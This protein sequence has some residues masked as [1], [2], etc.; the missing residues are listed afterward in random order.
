MIAPSI[1]IDPTILNQ[2]CKQHGVSRLALFGSAVRDDFDA[3]R[4]DIDLLVDFSPGAS[5]SLFKLVRMEQA[6]SRI[7]GRPVDLTTTGSLSK[8]FRDDVMSAAVVLY[9]AS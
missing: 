7:V 9:D 8:Y 6:L 5:K 4:S 2:F 3:A 1:S